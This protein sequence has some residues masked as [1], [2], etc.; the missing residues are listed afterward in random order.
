MYFEFPFFK[1]FFVFFFEGLVPAL[2]QRLSTVLTIE[3]MMGVMLGKLIMMGEVLGKL[4]W[5]YTTASDS[6]W[7]TPVN[8]LLLSI[9]INCWLFG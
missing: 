5:N 6:H 9:F 1:F 2:F 3:D 7:S 4:N 8:W